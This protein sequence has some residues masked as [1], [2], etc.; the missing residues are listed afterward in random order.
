MFHLA[1]LQVL[2]ATVD[3]SRYVLKGGANL[4]FFY[5][6][7]RRSQDIDLDLADPA[8]WGLEERVDRVLA[9]KVFREILDLARITMSPPTKPKQT[10]TTRRW[11]FSVEAPGGRLNTKIE[12]SGRTQPDVEFEL[13]TLTPAI[14]RELGLKAIRVQRYLPPA[15]IRQKIGALAGRS[16]TEPRDVF[17]LDLLLA[18]FPTAITASDIDVATIGEAIEAAYAI[19]YADFDALVVRYLEPDYVDLYRRP[20]VWDEMVLKVTEALSRLI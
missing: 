18:R 6:S 5:G 1:F 15:A 16:Q 8:D 12:F 19:D 7:P 4:R 11:K 10:A 20:E 2:S 13:E 3:P 17:D 14:G 9:S